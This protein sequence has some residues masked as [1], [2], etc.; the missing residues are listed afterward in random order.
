MPTIFESLTQYCQDNR[1]KMPGRSP[2]CFIGREVL[3]KWHI[4][5]YDEN[6]VYTWSEEPTGRYQ[7]ISYPAFFVPTIIDIIDQFFI[8]QR[9][10]LE[11][12]RT[13]CY[14]VQRRPFRYPYRRDQLPLAKGFGRDSKAL[15]NPS[16][17]LSYPLNKGF[18]GVAQALSRT[19]GTL[20]HPLHKGSSRDLHTLAKGFA[21]DVQAF[22]KGYTSVR[23]GITKVSQSLTQ[24]LDTK[25]RKRIY[26]PKKS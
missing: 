23:E 1:Q 15:S 6:F 3:K 2:R 18:E 19:Y 25:K 13:G 5:Q 4:G 9:E 20:W 12:A 10:K 21:R 22:N 8:A 17:T 7:V 16:I 14:V 24:G 11:K 26:Y